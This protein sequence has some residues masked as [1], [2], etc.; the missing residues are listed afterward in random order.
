MIQAG[1]VAGPIFHNRTTWSDFW[2]GP[3]ENTWEVLVPQ[4]DHV[5]PTPPKRPLSKGLFLGGPDRS[6]PCKG[7][8]WSG[9]PNRFE[10]RTARHGNKRTRSS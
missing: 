9:G 6:L 7:D 1:P 8:L 10:R 5:G 3:A 2:S 4:S